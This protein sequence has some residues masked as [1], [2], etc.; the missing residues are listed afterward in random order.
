VR[1]SLKPAGGRSGAV[2]A[3]GERSAQRVP[4]RQALFGLGALLAGG[5]LCLTKPAHAQLQ[6]KKQL[7]Q[8]RLE[9]KERKAQPTP[10]AVPASDWPKWSRDAASAVRQAVNTWRSSATLSGVTVQG[11]I[12]AG[13][14]LVGPA[15]LPSL[16]ASLRAAAVP[17]E[18]AAAFASA[19]ATAWS[20]WAASVRVPGLPWYPAFIAYPGPVAPPQPNIPTPL[21]ALVMDRSPFAANTLAA[22]IKTLLGARAGEDGAA[23]AVDEFAEEHALRFEIFCATCMLTQVLGSGPVV[24]FA[25][26]IVPVGQVVGGSAT[27]SPGGLTG[28]W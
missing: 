12:A 21:T 28:T 27:M 2:P 11:P 22:N 16:L 23:R 15:L 3:N 10:K 13:G 1:L 18:V 8:E 20:Q 25:P 4:R 14:F 24:G 17:A 6:P 7:P 5:G 26:P 19:V 9:P